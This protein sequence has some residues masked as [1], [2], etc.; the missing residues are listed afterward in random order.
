V[1]AVVGRQ[2]REHG[3]LDLAIDEAQLAALLDRLDSLG[4][5]IS[6]DWLPARVELTAP[7]GRRVDLHPVRFSPD[8]SGV[9]RG[10]GTDHFHY[11]AGSFTTGTIDGRVVRCLG[12]ELQL[13]FRQGYPPRDIDVHDVALLEGL[14]SSKVSA[15]QGKIEE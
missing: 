9:Q 10:R 6:V 4:F 15:E 13:T 14:R 1:D 5:V 7:D 3:D 2:T 12:V 8:G 11:P